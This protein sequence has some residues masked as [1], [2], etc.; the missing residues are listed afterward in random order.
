[1]TELERLLKELNEINESI[2]EHLETRRTADADEVPFINTE[3]DHCYWRRSR[4]QEQIAQ[5]RCAA[6]K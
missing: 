4:I 5:A 6:A 3:L 1:M 2:K